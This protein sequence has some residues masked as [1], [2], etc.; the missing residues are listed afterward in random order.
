MIV[1]VL[2]MGELLGNK[3]DIIFE[4]MNLMLS[5]WYVFCFI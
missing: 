4:Y 3:V 5:K 1:I 2:S